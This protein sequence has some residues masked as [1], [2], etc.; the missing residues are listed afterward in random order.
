MYG[1]K[2]SH[3]D[4][5]GVELRCQ[6]QSGVFAVHAA[7]CPGGLGELAYPLVSDLKKEI[8][9]AYGVLTGMHEISKAQLC[10][11]PCSGTDESTAEL[12]QAAARLA[13]TV[14]RTGSST[15]CPCY[16]CFI[17]FLI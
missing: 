15:R 14:C 4:M 3:H 10:S 2:R 9:E 6:I 5:P 12:A 1:S 13:R 8:S 17:I 16:I 7:G 11:T